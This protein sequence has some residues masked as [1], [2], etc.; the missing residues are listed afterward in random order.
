MA[1]STL[2]PFITVFRPS[3]RDIG[4]PTYDEF[5]KLFEKWKRR[6][7]Y[8]Q[9]I[10]RNIRKN[11]IEVNKYQLYDFTSPPKIL[12]IKPV[13][14]GPKRSTRSNLPNIVIKQTIASL[15]KRYVICTV[16]KPQHV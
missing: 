2:K 11:N 9:K 13:V 6:K 8:R 16:N 5:E 1:T 3:T 14:L 4:E 15:A 7:E 12:E 10:E